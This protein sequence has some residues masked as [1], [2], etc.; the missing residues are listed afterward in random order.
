M[1]GFEIVIFDPLALCCFFTHTK[2]KLLP[3]SFCLHAVAAAFAV[4][5]PHLD[6][7]MSRW[8]GHTM[9]HGYSF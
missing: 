4:L 2:N 7:A 5:L 8:M 3:L 9:D 1:N 6:H